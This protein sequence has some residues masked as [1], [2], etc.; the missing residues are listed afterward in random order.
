MSRYFIRGNLGFPQGAK[1]AQGL[2][3]EAALT[4]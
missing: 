3:S 4:P 2:S 1:S